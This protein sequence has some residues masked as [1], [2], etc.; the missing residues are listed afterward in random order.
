[1]GEAKRTTKLT[2]SFDP[3]NK[4][5]MNSSKREYLELTKQILDKARVF[6]CNFFLANRNKLEEQVTYFSKKHKKYET[7]K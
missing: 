4:K 3:S 2:L 5:A 6:Y 7:H 1:M